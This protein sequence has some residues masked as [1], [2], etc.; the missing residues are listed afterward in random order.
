MNW[1]GN[2]V[3]DKLAE[4][5]ISTGIHYPIALPNLSAYSYLEYKPEDFSVATAYANEILSLPMYPELSEEQ[6]AYVCEE[7]IKIALPVKER[8]K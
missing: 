8:K 4:K 6:V 1:D 2:E 7:L 3:R 5:G